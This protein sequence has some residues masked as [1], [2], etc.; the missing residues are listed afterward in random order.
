MINLKKRGSASLE[1]CIVIPAITVFVTLMLLVNF[2]FF[3]AVNDLEDSEYTSRN[4]Y[5]VISRAVRVI[6]ET[7]GDIYDYFFG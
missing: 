7:G 2:K 5:P 1:A 6:F 4:N 3:G